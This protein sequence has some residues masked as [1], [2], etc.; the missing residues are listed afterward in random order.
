[1][2]FHSKRRSRRIYLATVT[3]AVLLAAAAVAVGTKQG[4]ST[5]SAAEGSL[6]AT[7]VPAAPEPLTTSDADSIARAYASEQA[8]E[9]APSNQE[10]VKTTRAAAI[11]AL[12]PGGRHQVAESPAEMQSWL[13]SSV[14]VEVLHGTFKLT[15]APVPSGHLQPTGNVLTEVIDAATGQVSSIALTNEGPDQ[16]TLEG[17]G[18]VR[19]V[20]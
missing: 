6:G 10:A 16:A 18:A 11:A 20:G 15:D 12:F 2:R 1:M 3:L 9:D 8:G 4:S 7:V 5:A 17:L 14:Y 19:D 13:A